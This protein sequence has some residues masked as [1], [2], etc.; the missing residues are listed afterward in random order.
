LAGVFGL[1]AFALLWGYYIFFETLW[2]GQSPGKRWVG[3][4]VIAHDGTPIG[5]SATLIRNLVRIVDFLPLY[6]GIGVVT[7]FIDRQSRRLGDFAAGTLVVYERGA[8]TLEHLERATEQLEVALTRHDQAPGSG[9][10]RLSLQRL[11]NRH[12][13]LARS[14]LSRQPD[15]HNREQLAVLL[16]QK[17][18]SAMELPVRALSYTD[19]ISLLEAVA[20]HI[21]KPVD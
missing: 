15:L 12:V 16:A 17:L 7:M 1:V 20:G 11:Q 13:T 2:N 5:V 3:L 9:Y 4:R 10:P 6:Y 21:R 14:F 19:A 8:I 18:Q